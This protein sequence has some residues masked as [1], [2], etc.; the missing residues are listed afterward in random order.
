MLKSLSCNRSAEIVL[1]SV[2]ADPFVAQLVVSGGFN[3]CCFGEGRIYTTSVKVADY[4]KLVYKC[5]IFN[6]ALYDGTLLSVHSKFF[7]GLVLM[8]IPGAPLRVVRVLNVNSLHSG[9]R[10]SGQ[11]PPE[12]CRHIL[13]LCPHSLLL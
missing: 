6:M 2:K 12:L 11:S 3:V 9:C 13:S 10:G 4:Y 1:G 7:P 8:E 5:D